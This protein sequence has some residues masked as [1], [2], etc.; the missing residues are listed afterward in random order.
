MRRALVIVG[1]SVAAL[2]SVAWNTP[3]IKSKAIIILYENDNFTGRSVEINADIDDLTAVNFNDQASSLRL[4]IGY[5]ATFF[6]DAGGKG[7]F[8]TF[9]CP[10][11][12]GLQVSDYC[13][14]ASIGGQVATGTL[15]QFRTD[16]SHGCVHWWNDRITSIKRIMPADTTQPQG[17]IDEGHAD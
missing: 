14:I 15:C 10:P 11:P 12:I 1:V 16:N 9:N 3:A 17:R 7:E 5:Q 2:A 13:E 4:R 6:D 8:F